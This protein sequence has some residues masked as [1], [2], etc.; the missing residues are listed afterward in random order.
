METTAMAAV[1]PRRELLVPLAAMYTVKKMALV[2]AAV[3]P[4]NIIGQGHLL[5][6]FL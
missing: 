1:K 6:L 5:A 3:A 4:S 2:T